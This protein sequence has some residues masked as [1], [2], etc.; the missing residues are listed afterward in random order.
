LLKPLV[1]SLIVKKFKGKLPPMAQI[2]LLTGATGY[3]GPRLGKALRE[4][5]YLALGR[6]RNSNP[7]AFCD[8]N[9]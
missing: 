5:E 6:W 3:I 4:R 1:A 8:I 7:G 9:L 2:V